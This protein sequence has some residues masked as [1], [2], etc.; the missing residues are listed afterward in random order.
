MVAGL[1]RTITAGLLASQLLVGTPERGERLT[2]PPG[3]VPPTLFGMH[4]HHAGVPTPWPEVP[5]AAWRLWDAYVS[6]S[7]LEPRRGEWRFETLD[8]Y[9]ALAE[10]HHVEVLLVL[11]LTPGWAAARPVEKSAYEPGNASVPKDLDDW[12][13]FVAEVTRRYKGRIAAYEIWNEPDLRQTWTG[14]VEQMVALTR[15]ASQVIRAIDPAARIVSPAAAGVDVKWLADFLAKGGGQYV[16]VIGYHFYVTP[17]PPE[18]MVPLIR[19][20]QRVMADHG[21]AG[22]PLWNT[23]TGWAHPKHFPS[24]DLAAAYVGRSYLLNWAAGVERLYWY[25]WDNHRW[26]SLEMTQ[27]DDRTLRPAAKAYAAIQEW[28]VGAQVGSCEEDMSH[29]WIC[30][31]KRDGKA[32]WILWNANGSR[33]FPIPMDWH[34]ARTTRLLGETRPI[35]SKTFKVGPTP[36][37]VTSEP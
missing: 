10:G 11:G 6:W 30:A 21:V 34:T 2:P 33:A 20:V 17:K 35:T 5:F 28:L 36:V 31:L 1:R 37:L 23:E 16:D 19:Q 7:A 18:A 29:M 26:V 13:K 15:E 27:A 25:A 22:K 8:R 4:M 12:R 32:E 9:L 24:E 3:L 14:S